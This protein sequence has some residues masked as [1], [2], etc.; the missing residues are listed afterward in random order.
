MQSCYKPHLKSHSSDLNCS[1]CK[2][3]RIN[4]KSNI[5]RI[6]IIVATLFHHLVKNKHIN[7]IVILKY[8]L[9]CTK[10]RKKSHYKMGQKYYIQIYNK[11]SP[12]NSSQDQKQVYPPTNKWYENL[13]ATQFNNANF[14]CQGNCGSWCQVKICFQQ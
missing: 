12:M 7:F 11:A 6:K 4:H 9:H 3:L 1:F 14:Y 5:K 10:G 2:S 8:A 13:N